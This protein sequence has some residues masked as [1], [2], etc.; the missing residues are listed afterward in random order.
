MAW[1]LVSTHT[2]DKLGLMYSCPVGNPVPVQTLETIVDDV[3]LPTLARAPIH[4][5]G[6]DQHAVNVSALQ[7]KPDKLWSLPETLPFLS[8]F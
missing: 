1:T 6:Q 7:I 4:P 8:I 2:D 5:G 3:P